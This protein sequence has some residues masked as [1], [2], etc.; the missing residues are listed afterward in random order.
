M[1][2]G[3]SP[4]IKRDII[5]AYLLKSR[6]TDE[7]SLLS[8]DMHNVLAYWCS[9]QEAITKQLDEVSPTNELFYRGARCSLKQLLREAELL[10]SQAERAFSSVFPLVA[11]VPLQSNLCEVDSD[12]D[13]S[14]ES[15]DS[16]EED[17]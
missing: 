15:E 13:S 1:P 10:H 7:L 5:Q 4:A 9:R 8:S 3:T 14:S 12:T 17:M 11:S 6:S 16:G 2:G